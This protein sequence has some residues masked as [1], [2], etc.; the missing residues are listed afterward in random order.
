MQENI[1]ELMV[2][3]TTE[4]EKNLDASQCYAEELAATDGPNEDYIK[5]VCGQ[6][7]IEPT[8]LNFRVD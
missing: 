7:V 5:K 2:K 4:F 8:E 1:R 6:T 3:E